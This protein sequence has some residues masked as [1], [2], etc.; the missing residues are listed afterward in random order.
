MKGFEFALCNG[1]RQLLSR[2]AELG[3]SG[4]SDWCRVSSKGAQH[5]L[6]GIWSHPSLLEPLKDI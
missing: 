3:C 4:I 5:R 1:R 2:R 6:G